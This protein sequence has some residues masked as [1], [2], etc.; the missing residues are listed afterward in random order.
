M[1]K[2]LFTILSVIPL[3]QVE[4]LKSIIWDHKTKDY[5]EPCTYLTSSKAFLAFFNSSFIVR[6]S[7]TLAYIL[8]CFLT[9]KIISST[10]PWTEVES[11]LG[12]QIWKTPALVPVCQSP[13]TCGSSPIWT[14]SQGLR[15]SQQS[16]CKDSCHPHIH[17]T[18]IVALSKTS[19]AWRVLVKICSSCIKIGIPSPF[20]DVSL[21]HLPLSLSFFVKCVIACI[22]ACVQIVK[23]WTTACFPNVATWIA[24]LT[25]PL[26]CPRLA[27]RLHHYCSPLPF[28]LLCSPLQEKEFCV[29]AMSSDLS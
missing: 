8:G 1:Y 25:L 13:W 23:F 17:T 7:R 27:R 3:F 12:N 5:F 11:C 28:Y 20:P 15:G 22:H 16:L 14:P 18:C 19:Y 21:N 2:P 26:C 4:R 24:R 9:R 6:S 29:F 10:C